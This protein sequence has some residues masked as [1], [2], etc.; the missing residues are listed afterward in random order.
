MSLTD[1]LPPRRR[2][3]LAEPA[4]VTSPPAFPAP[5]VS[6]LM[7]RVFGERPD[8]V[9]RGGDRQGAPRKFEVAFDV[10]KRGAEA[11]DEL[12]HRCEELRAEIVALT[13]R[14]RVELE[15]S[16]RQTRE[17]QQLATV[18]KAKYEDS[19]VQLSDMEARAEAAES[20]AGGRRAP[21]RDGR[22][23]GQ[24]DGADRDRPPR[25]DPGGVRQLLGRTGRDRVERIQPLV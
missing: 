16:E 6:R 25:R 20:R 5:D 22:A 11:L 19:Q 14:S 18:M 3:A 7:L 10:L 8:D 2:I 12:Q 9:D 13:E 1:Y 4:T 15:A 24:S 23:S 17:W 21:R